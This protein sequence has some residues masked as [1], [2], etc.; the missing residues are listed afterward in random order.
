MPIASTRQPAIASSGWR[1]SST[2][3]GWWNTMLLPL[4]SSRRKTLD[5]VS[6]HRSQSMQVEST[7]QAP[8]TFCGNRLFLSAMMFCLSLYVFHWDSRDRLDAFGPSSRNVHKSSLP[9]SGQ[10]E[11][12]PSFTLL[13]DKLS[14]FGATQNFQLLFQSN[15]VR[16]DRRLLPGDC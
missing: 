2:V 15:T 16:R 7:Y 5:A 4:S 11:P 3:S 6:R 13:Q 9:N 1:S 10:Q 8:G 14:F 12:L